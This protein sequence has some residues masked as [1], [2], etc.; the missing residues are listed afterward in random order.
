[1]TDSNITLPA[2]N[3][4]ATMFGCSDDTG[5]VEQLI[6]QM[7]EII[8]KEMGSFRN[9]KFSPDVALNIFVRQ[10]IND[11]GSCRQAL[12]DAISADLIDASNLDTG[13]YCHA[14]EKL[15]ESL[16]TQYVALICN[17][18]Y[19]RFSS[20]IQ[21]K[22]HGYNIKMVDGT[23]IS[24]PD[25]A[26]N[27]E[28]YPQPD[29]QEPGIG[30][31][32]LRMVMVFC[33]FTGSV[34]KYSYG[35]YAGKQTGEHSLF[36]AVM[37]DCVSAM[38]LIVG[39]RYY[40]SYWLLWALKAKGADGLFEAHGARNIDFRTGAKVGKLDHIAVWSKPK[41]PKWMSA[42]E[43]SVVPDE[44][45]VREFKYGKK[46][47][48]TTILDVE[49][50]SRVKLGQLYK[51]R[52][53]VETDIGAIKTTMKMDILRCKTPENISR[54]IGAHMVAYNLTRLLI[55]QTSIQ[56]KRKP[57]EISHQAAMQLIASFKTAL[58]NAKTKDEF[59]KII[60]KVMG[61]LSK[62]IVRNR[63]GRK[64]PREV[65]RRPKPYPRLTKS[66]AA[67]KAAML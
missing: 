21:S 60:N 24:M 38:D 1:M 48:V 50:F 41:K 57:R 42:H 58:L 14:R 45:L 4:L 6:S 62:Q 63:P 33:F 19:Q 52:W 15:P 20:V 23:T 39:D 37:D 30:F 18:T 36:R 7:K 9:T 56:T 67:S 27:Q 12:A 29:T 64:E 65:K 22:W 28:A 61:L 43:Y 3:N 16:F 2:I 5:H 8:Y 53:C 54:E 31:P 34:V 35:S 49:T 55:V 59:K 40:P 11:N 17:F 44:M 10:A 26:E 47:I 66:R 13:A 46:N 51:Q 25:T 32:L